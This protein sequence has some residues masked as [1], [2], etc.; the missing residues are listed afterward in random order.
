[1]YLFGFPGPETPG[2]PVLFTALHSTGLFHPKSGIEPHHIVGAICR[3]W[4]V[5]FCFITGATSIGPEVQ[6]MLTGALFASLFSSYFGQNKYPRTSRILLLCGMASGLACFFSL[7]TSSILFALEIPSRG[8]AFM[9]GLPAILAA[10]VT[11]C[12]VNAAVQ[13][14]QWGGQLDLG[15]LS[16]PA[17]NINLL[18]GVVCGVLGYIPARSFLFLVD[19][20]KHYLAKFNLTMARPYHWIG[21]IVVFA[22][23]TGFL[24]AINPYSMFYSETELKTIVTL[25]EQPLPHYS[26][27]LYGI[28]QFGSSDPIKLKAWELLVT[29]IIKTFNVAVCALYF[30]GGV[31]WPLYYA[32]MSLGAAWATWLNCSANTVLLYMLATGVAAEVS[33]LKNPLGAA[34]V[35]VMQVSSS[36]QNP[37]PISAALE[38]CAI[39]GF[40]SWFLTYNNPYFPPNMQRPR[41]PDDSFFDFMA[42]RQKDPQ[43]GDTAVAP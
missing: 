7:P 12:Y 23:I 19:F 32:G 34:V 39:A 1:M 3:I 18:L 21:S 31:I 16:V 30:P 43:Q 28:S 13:Q 20:G 17:T 29:S 37:A 38:T 24:S 42:V 5:N 22:I 27:V 6:C 41:Q 36:S 2:M 15:D 10:S 40:I 14:V 33:A 11:A 26:H 8:L 25:G 35:M 4:I 9:E